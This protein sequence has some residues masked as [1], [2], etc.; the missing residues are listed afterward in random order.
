MK[1]NRRRREKLGYAHISVVIPAKAGIQEPRR[2]V[3]DSKH[4]AACSLAPACAGATEEQ[5]D[6][7]GSS[8]SLEDCPK[9][10][11]NPPFPRPSLRGKIA[12]LMTWRSPRLLRSLRTPLAAGAMALAAASLSG[13]I[14]AAAGA[15]AGAGYQLTAE[16]PVT[17]QVRDA[18]L[19]A[20]IQQSW[21]EFNPQLHEDLSTTVYEGRVLLT[22]VVPSEDW[23]GEAVKR[24]WKVDGVKEVYDEIQ[25][26]PEE[27]FQEDVSDDAITSKLKAQ[28][29]ADGDVKSINYLV[30]TVKGVVYIMG[31]A[32][33]NA[34]RDRV[35]DHAR[36]IGD[37]KRVVSY[38]QIRS[39]EPPKPETAARPAAPA[40][41]AAT[42]AASGGAVSLP[43]PRQS[44]DVEPLK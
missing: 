4:I 3:P 37:V 7:S 27:N 41:A 36:N 25:V 11:A 20:A 43:T 16:R 31:T 39:G 19:A 5:F 2:T 24:A 21:K 22:G 6:L 12:A 9:I 18:G 35:V 26:G 10:A 8:S 33:S 28:L 38:V 14:L 1:Q 15:G 42:P 13:C 17:D 32:R 29:I 30:T 34:E 44:I 23:R 40:A